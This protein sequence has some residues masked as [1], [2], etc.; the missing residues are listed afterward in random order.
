MSVIRAI[1]RSRLSVAIVAAAA[2]VLATAGV[3]VAVFPGEVIKGCVKN[4]TGA[5]RII[6]TGTCHSSEHVISW[7][8]Q[9]PPGKNGKNGAA[10]GASF[11]ETNTVDLTP[12]DAFHKVLSA[13]LAAGTWIAFG[14]VE[15]RNHDTSVG[16]SFQ[17]E[18]E[19]LD[20]AGG[21]L[22]SDDVVWNHTPTA[23]DEDTYLPIQ[24]ALTVVNGYTPKLFCD[25]GTNSDATNQTVQIGSANLVAVQT[26]KN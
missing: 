8:K 13:P 11:L 3:A 14:R 15:I 19:I 26:A 12:T 9:G 6:S 22:T 20:G 17:V 16:H 7:N 4:G 10:D 5:L 24:G 25:A 18:C 2:A 21:N 1:T 23:V